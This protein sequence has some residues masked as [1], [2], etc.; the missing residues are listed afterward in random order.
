RRRRRIATAATVAHPLAIPLAV[1]VTGPVEIPTEEPTAGSDP[2]FQLVNAEAFQAVGHGRVSLGGVDSGESEC[3]IF[4]PTVPNR[5]S[6][7]YFPVCQGNIA[8]L[9]LFS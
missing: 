4:R 6:S 5:K 8:I 1:P 7:L 9:I 3:L 2:G